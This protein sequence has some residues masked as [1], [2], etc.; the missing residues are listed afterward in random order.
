MKKIIILL[1]VVCQLKHIAQT[2]A[3]VLE[4]T[5][6][7][8]RNT[9]FLQVWDTIPNV[10][11]VPTIGPNQLWDYT[12]TNGQFLNIVD[13]FPIT[14]VDPASTPYG[15]YFPNATHAAFMR[16]PFQARFLVDSNYTYWQI[17]KTGMYV[18]GGFNTKSIIDSSMT[19]YNKEFFS[20]EFFAYQNFLQ[21]TSQ[22]VGYL[23]NVAGFKA[24]VKG[25][26]IKTTTYV[27]Y[28]TLKLPYATYNNVALIR[29]NRAQVDSIFVDL[30]N[31]NNYTFLTINSGSS[32]GYN[33]LRNNTFGS[34]YLMYLHVTPN[35]TS[36]E[37]GWYNLP[38]NVGSISGKVFANSNETQV[39]S[40]GEVYLYR[41][42]SNYTKND[43][44]A[45]SKLDSQGNFKFDS[46][47]YGEYRLA[48][49]P[50]PS[51]YANSKITYLGDTTNWIDAATVIT[52]NSVS[53]GH[54]IHLQY[55]PSPSGTSSLTGVI[56][57]DWSFSKGMSA[58]ASNPVTGIGIV[59]KKHP[60][61]VS[62]RVL[63]TDSTGKFD[64]GT[65]EDGVYNLFVDIPGLHMTGTYNFT[66]SNGA[67]VNG[68]DFTVGK[69]SIH[70]INSAVIGVNEI[71]GS[72]Y[73]T[74]DVKA[75][76]NPFK[77]Q[78]SIELNGRASATDN[79]HVLN[80]LGKEL[81]IKKS[82]VLSEHKTTHHIALDDKDIP[83]GV[84]IVK[85]T[86]QEKTASLRIIKQ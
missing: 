14:T 60:N 48:A 7:P 46:I 65:L 80:M 55:H 54:K 66:V 8:V 26:R 32:I 29:E 40:S 37:W 69:D 45:K 50:T 25:R 63:V 28:G 64:L 15:Q 5:Y 34:N 79:I 6:L 76:P 1:V 51:L 58:L 19:F 57:E 42:Y 21:D 36:V 30:F 33:F 84:Y 75:Y 62:A 78:L 71:I 22:Y 10:M 73:N 44:L 27:G 16:T 49:R 18:V 43:I 17:D 53:S 67:S 24:R 2:N 4:G 31:T 61:N 20:P 47:P 38:V 56:G 41:E 72:K 82:T 11:S 77:N 85:I 13:T 52:T 39:V 35:N 86:H 3:P 12:Q 23:K 81:N 68:L 9:T 83:A 74:I 70:P 59:V